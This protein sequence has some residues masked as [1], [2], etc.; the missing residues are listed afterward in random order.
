MSKIDDEL[1]LHI[2]RLE[3]RAE[4][5]R[6]IRSMLA[7]DPELAAQ[8]LGILL[9]HHATA[10]VPADPQAAELYSTARRKAAP[11]LDRITAFL[12]LGGNDWRSVRQIADGTGLPRNAI[13]FVFYNSKHKDRFESQSLGPKEKVWRLAPIAKLAAQEDDETAYDLGGRPIPK[14]WAEGKPT[15]YGGSVWRS[16]ET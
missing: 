16:D 7:D 10:A 8:L 1:A 2:Q 9:H 4:K 15:P 13:N 14:D 5:L 11:H 3:S 12:Q 6:A